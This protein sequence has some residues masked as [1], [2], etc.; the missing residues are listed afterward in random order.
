MLSD[1]QPSPPQNPPQRTGPPGPGEQVSIGADFVFQEKAGT[2]VPV[3]AGDMGLTMKTVVSPVG[4]MPFSKQHATAPTFP[5]DG[6]KKHQAM[7]GAFPLQVRSHISTRL[8]RQS[9]QQE[10]PSPFVICARVRKHQL[11]KPLKRCKQ[12]FNK[13]LIRDSQKREM[14]EKGWIV[15]NCDIQ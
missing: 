12:S 1:P 3:L 10:H 5:P 14:G 4:S 8:I 6:T 2:H 7:F 9:Q 15:R 11:R 13:L